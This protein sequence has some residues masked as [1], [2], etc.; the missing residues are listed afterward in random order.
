MKKLKLGI[1]LTALLLFMLSMSSFGQQL[2][3]GQLEGPVQVSANRNGPTVYEQFNPLS[4][5]FI[6]SQEY[7]DPGLAANTTF[8][9]DDFVVPAG[10]TWNVS[11]VNLA[12]AYFDWIGNPIYAI[13]LFIYTDNN[14]VPGEVIHSLTYLSDYNEIEIQP[15]PRLCKYEITLPEAIQFTEGHYWICAQSVGDETNRWGWMTHASPTIE[16]EYQ[17]KNPGD[18]LGWGYTDWTAGSAIAWG[19][20]NLAFG[21]YGAGLDNDLSMVSIDQPVTGSELSSTEQITV[22]VKN[23]STSVM[24]G[25]NLSYSVDGGAVVTENVGSFSLAANQTGQYTFVATADFSTPGIHHVQAV[26]SATGDPLPG[27]DTIDKS[28]YNLGIVYA[29]PATGEQTITSCGAT[30]TDSGGFEGNFG[31]Y[32]NAVTT[33]NPANAGDRI[34][35]TFL[36]FDASWGGFKIF[37]G[38]DTLAPLM[39]TWFGTNGPGVITA[40]NASGSL[41]IHFMGPGWENT[42]GWVAFISCITPV[43]DDFAI[44]DLKCSLA[45]IFVGDVPVLSAK[46]QNYGSSSQE[47]TVTF[48][49]NG[50]E[51]GSQLTGLLGPADTAWVSVPWTPV[52]AGNFLLEASVPSDDGLDP[53]DFMIIEKQVYPFGAFFEDFEGAQ[54]PPENWRHGGFWG[55]NSW[56]PYTGGF[57]AECFVGYTQSDTLIS[58][59]L[60]VE[61]GG[62]LTFSAKTSLWWPGNLDIYWIEEATGIRSFVQNI[63]MDAFSYNNFEVDLSAHTGI[64]RVGFF[65]NV[66]DPYAFSGQVLLDNVLGTGINVYFDNYDLKA[67]ELTGNVYYNVNEE[68]VYTFNIRNDGLVAIPSVE[69]NVR[70]M[71]GGEVPEVLLSLPGND[72]ASFETQTYEFPYSFNSIGEFRVYAEIE[73]A[74][75]EYLANNKSQAINLHG[76]ASASEVVGVGEDIIY[77]NWPIEF[78]VKKSLSETIYTS[79]EINRT[80]VIFGIG[81]EYNFK[82]D[83]QDAPVRI[84]MGETDTLNLQTWIPATEMTLVYE[85]LLNIPK[86]KHTVYIPFQTPFNYS[87]GSKNLVILTEKIGDH[88]RTEQIYYGYGAMHLST[89]VAA[90]DVSIPDPYNPPA[91]GG[92]STNLSPNIRFVFNDNLGLAGGTVSEQGG[93]PIEGAKV[94]IDELNITGYTDASGNYQLPYVPAG[95]FS[96]TAD[97]FTYQPLTKALGVTAGNAT[98]LDFELG[99]LDLISLS[100]HITGN[101]DPATGIAGA[102]ISL[103]GYSDYTVTSGSDG[104]FLI[105][106]VYSNNTYQITVLADGYDTYTSSVVVENSAIDLGN[107][108]LTESLLIP[109]TVYA[110]AA[111]DQAV[112]EWAVP[113]SSAQQ[114]IAF[115]DG[116]HENGYAAEPFET[117]WLGNYF[118][119]EQMATVTSF[120]IYWASYTLINRQA[121][122]LDIFDEQA[123]LIISSDEFLSGVDEWVNVDIPNLTLQGNIYVMVRWSGEPAQ[124]T[125]MA[126]DSATVTPDNARY[127]Y[128]DGTFGLL[129]ELTGQH[130]S[131]IIHANAMLDGNAKYAGRAVN[132]YNISLGMVSDIANAGNWTMLNSEP[133]TLAEFTDLNWP[134]AASGDYVY[135]VKAIYTNG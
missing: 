72:I 128:P 13:N 101:N 58:P 127:L 50:V 103:S 125:F 29:M 41:T 64:G 71:K 42:T 31:D 107:I 27:N 38:P 26:T 116:S 99:L 135:A 129:S 53:N 80:G 36:E 89:L 82:S 132:S 109:Y 40:L 69:Y 68:A 44:T 4:D 35:L 88:G 34:R 90:S 5:G 96:A 78:S 118:P 49:A 124:S 74:A 21:F 16:N 97:K 9:A 56:D 120:D 105:E 18:G 92:M 95:D 130:G 51:I 104:N 11:Y 79:D 102:T 87:D 70:L 75:D 60:N 66:T 111:E 37:N 12:G 55:R 122:Y 14:G 81:Y 61:A 77:T 3:Y 133:L 119:M 33:I 93:V 65:V 108:V 106:G 83:E 10:E 46:V 19:D 54:F 17:W 86:G 62:M 25:F 43:A 67:K 47:K 91:S 39:G 112:I 117:V 52:D 8:A 121:M 6:S 123:N 85:G 76:L 59:R 1:T 32:D 110:Q 131:F 84:W 94:V 48:T 134:P 114:V 15:L 24:T 98:D 63:V 23:E 28:L 20:Y 30:F 115:D 2:I 57:H 22:S 113:S 45:T 126:F 100:G 73:Y 7:T